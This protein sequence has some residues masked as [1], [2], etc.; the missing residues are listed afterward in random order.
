[1]ITERKN[2]VMNLSKNLKDRYPF[3]MSMY[4]FEDQ[5]Q[6]VKDYISHYLVDISKNDKKI[7][8]YISLVDWFANKTLDVSFH[9]L[10]H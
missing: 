1:M 6:G 9:Q 2:E 7:L 4:A 5:F 10:H 3:F 8:E